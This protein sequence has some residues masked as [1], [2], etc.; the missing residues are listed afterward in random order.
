MLFHNDWR[1]YHNIALVLLVTVIDSTEYYNHFCSELA[2]AESIACVEMKEYRKTN[3]NRFGWN[4]KAHTVIDC[5][6]E[7]NKKQG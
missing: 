1:K 5:V 3:F 2:F 6:Y 4:V 7:F